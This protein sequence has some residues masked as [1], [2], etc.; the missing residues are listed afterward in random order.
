[1]NYKRFYSRHALY[2]TVPDPVKGQK[3]ELSILC[4]SCVYSS[5]YSAPGANC[6]PQR[7]C[8]C[9][10]VYSTHAC[11]PLHM[12]T[13]VRNVLN[14]IILTSMSPKKISARQWEKK[15]IH[16]MWAGA[17]Y[18]QDMLANREQKSFAVIFTGMYFNTQV[19]TETIATML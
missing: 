7:V 15:N 14:L 11:S 17:N 8:V 16:S 13:T 12:C 3:E 4:S 6:N 5:L 9:V 10:R 18:K 19:R 2:N 1:M